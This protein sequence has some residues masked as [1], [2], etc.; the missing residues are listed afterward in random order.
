MADEVDTNKVGAPSEELASTIEDLINMLGSIGQ[1]SGSPH[2]FKCS[3][4]SVGDLENTMEN[5]NWIETF[6]RDFD[7]LSH[8][9]KGLNIRMYIYIVYRT[10]SVQPYLLSYKYSAR[11]NSGHSLRLY[12]APSNT[13]NP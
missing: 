12:S 4:P 6:E 7:S 9:E 10:A 2:G 8:H 5:E 11:P 13:T 1:F 3:V